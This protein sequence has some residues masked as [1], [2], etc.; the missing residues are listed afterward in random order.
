MDG[1]QKVMTSYED[2]GSREVNASKKANQKKS[3]FLFFLIIIKY[4]VTVAAFLEHA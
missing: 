2:A 3:Y 4:H 1:M